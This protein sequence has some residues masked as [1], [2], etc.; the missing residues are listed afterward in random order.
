MIMQICSFFF[1]SPDAPMVKLEQKVS[2]ALKK[3]LE[4][5]D[6]TV[7]NGPENKGKW[8]STKLNCC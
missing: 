3:V 8:F 2:P 6:L 1:I 4:K 7:H 5:L